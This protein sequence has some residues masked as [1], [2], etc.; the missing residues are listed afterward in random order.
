M[1]DTVGVVF[2]LGGGGKG[3]SK[4]LP[5][6]ES[7]FTPA[8]FFDSCEVRHNSHCGH[9]GSPR[10]CGRDVPVLL[11]A[12]ASSFL[13]CLCGGALDQPWRD[14][15][16]AA[17]HG[18]NG[19][20]LQVSCFGYGITP[21]RD[22]HFFSFRLPRGPLK[23]PGHRQAPL[24]IHLTFPFEP[25]RRRTYPSMVKEG[26]VKEE[27]EKDIQEEEEEGHQGEAKAGIHGTLSGHHD[28]ER[29]GQRRHG[30]GKGEQD[31][32]PSHPPTRSS[33]RQAPLHSLDARPF[34]PPQVRVA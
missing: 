21:R 6:R 20:L 29:E 1:H 12:A 22:I 16:Q 25:D 15:A 34:P 24:F 9:C 17:R 18:T 23:S 8:A 5:L 3:A 13:D 14:E 33:S 7:G 26:E 4:P 19:Q 11:R 27:K 30:Q 28:Q 32:H 10:A 31:M 2:F